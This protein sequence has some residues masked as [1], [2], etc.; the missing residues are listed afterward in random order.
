MKYLR[1]FEAEETPQKNELIYKY[2]TYFDSEEQFREWC[3]DKPINLPI[4]V[5]DLPTYDQEIGRLIGDI[6]TEVDLDDPKWNDLRS[7]EITFD[8]WKEVNKFNL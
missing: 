5:F 4:E 3:L 7:G 2:V 8:E 1:K 6:L